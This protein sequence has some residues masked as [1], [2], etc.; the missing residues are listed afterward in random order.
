MDM[1]ELLISLEGRVKTITLNLPE[2]KNPLTPNMFAGIKQAIEQ[3][4]TDGTRVIVLTGAGNDFSAGA[5]L[6]LGISNL[7]YGDV[8]Q[9]LGYVVN[10][11]ITAVRQVDIP[12]I[13]KVRGVCVGVGFSLALACDLIFA[14]ERAIFSPIFTRIGL[15]CDGG[16]AFFLPRLVGYHKAFELLVTAAMIKAED[17]L[18]MGIVNQVFAGE[19]LDTAVEKMAYRL[20][21]GPQ[22]AIR[23]VKAN[24]RAGME[25]SLVQTLEVEALNQ[26]SCFQSEDFRE[27]LQA[28]LEKRK[29]V[30]KGN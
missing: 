2:K 6:S 18:R 23:Q 28:F 7:P 11:V 24:L 5:D 19:L 27:G 10:P 20:A 1:Q 8:S 9:Y 12:F 3:S 4:L 30:F 14:E 16:S 25:S 13:A 17:A 29:P 22:V 26:R 15:A 21:N